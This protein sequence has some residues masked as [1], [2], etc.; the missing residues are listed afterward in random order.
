ML[1][2]IGS[3][4]RNDR[5]NKLRRFMIGLR[6]VVEKRRYGKSRTRLR[7]DGRQSGRSLDPNTPTCS[8]ARVG[9]S[10]QLGWGDEVTNTNQAK[11]TRLGPAFSW[12]AF[13]PSKTTAASR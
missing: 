13:T 10:G 6:P 8:D 11:P 1:P 7:T 3:V 2:V 4:V 9:D 5:G 12:K